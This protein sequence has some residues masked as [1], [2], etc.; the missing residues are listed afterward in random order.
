[1]RRAQAVLDG[2]G[3]RLF[4]I[5]PLGLMAMGY[6]KAGHS[7]LALEVISRALALVDTTG[8]CS[9][10]AELHRIR[11]EIQ[12]SLAL[13]EQEAETSFRQAIEIAREK[14]ERSLELRAAT[15]LARLLHRRGERAEARQAL[16]SIHGWF[17]EGFDTKDL[18]VATALLSSRSD[19][20]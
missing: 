13:S 19:Q 8:D 15:S 12:W 7:D 3:A 5:Y 18:Q 10:K 6:Q 1:M 9:W 4:R 11:G 17:T 16:E 2:I 14:S 20:G